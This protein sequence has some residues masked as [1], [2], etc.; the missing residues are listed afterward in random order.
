VKVTDTVREA[1]DLVRDR[2]FALLPVLGDA[3]ELVG[4]VRLPRL[5]AAGNSGGETAVLSTLLE[6]AHTVLS[7][8]SLIS[9]VVQM[10]DAGFRQFV[11]VDDVEASHLVGMMAISDFVRAHARAV[12]GPTDTPARTRSARPPATRRARQLMVPAAVV[13][14]GTRLDALLEGLVASAG[15][16]I[17]VEG[18][19]GKYSVVLLDY[20]RELGRDDELQNVLI[21]AD[22]AR[23]MPTVAHTADL[24][25]LV[26]AFSSGSP[27]ALLVT[28]SRTGLPVG[29]VTRGALA[30]VLLEWYATQPRAGSDRSSAPGT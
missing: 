28:D 20:V 22:V 6:P 1:L 12:P 15:K 10:N 24:S 4:V 18:P 13:P 16:A 21:A 17:I 19:E 26:Q 9:A 11:V 29:V 7:D 14:E 2:N 23:R 5:R 25:G 3:G 27:D 8:A 30:D